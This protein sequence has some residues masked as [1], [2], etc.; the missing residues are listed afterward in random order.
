MGQALT[1][2]NNN[3]VPLASRSS[4]QFRRG[5]AL[6]FLAGL[7]PGGLGRIEFALVGGLDRQQLSQL[8]LRGFLVDGLIRKS[9]AIYL[10]RLRGQGRES[11]TPK[12]ALYE[13]SQILAAGYKQSLGAG[14][15][16]E[17]NT[18][19]AIFERLRNSCVLGV[20]W[21]DRPVAGNR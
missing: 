16:R 10:G 1:D 13:H 5:F 19:R 7:E 18:A 11:A 8:R 15:S 6:Q 2:L 17:G 14:F 12:T 3:P 4:G 20:G 21:L 9:R